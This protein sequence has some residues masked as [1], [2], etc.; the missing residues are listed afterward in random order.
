MPRNNDYAKESLL[1]YLYHPTYWNRFIKTNR[2][3]YFQ[4]INVTGKFD[5]DDGEQYFSLLKSSKK[6]IEFI[7]VLNL[8]NKPNNSKFV[9]TN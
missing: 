8:L 7:K 1:N 6:I 9:T 5:K 4:Q 2:Y 3:K